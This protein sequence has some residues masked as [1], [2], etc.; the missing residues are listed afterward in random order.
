VDSKISRRLYFGHAKVIIFGEEFVKNR[1]KFMEVIDYLGRDPNINWAIRGMVADGEASKTAEMNPKDEKLLFRYLRGILDN[2]VTSGRILDVR[3]ND[4]LSMMMENGVGMLPRVHTASDEAK[5]SGLSLFKDYKYVG[6]LSEYDTLYFNTLNGTRNGGRV[7]INHDGLK[8]SFTTS[9][10]TRKVKLEN[11][12]VNTLEIGIHVHVEG[13]LSNIELKG[14]KE[15]DAEALAALE[16]ELKKTDEESCGF[17]IK[18]LQGE[19]K[20]DALGMGEYIRKYH[21]SIW[22]QVKDKWDKVYP[23]V[24]ITPVVDYRIRRIGLTK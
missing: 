11:S 22:D 24:K 10:T 5:I 6:Y 3:F 17:V 4:F 21:P 20:A 12:D 1:E 13:N 14:N 7:Y 2:E 19:F 18:K 8:A 15:L 16:Q 9:N 23:A